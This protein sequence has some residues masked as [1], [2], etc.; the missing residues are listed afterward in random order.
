[1]TISLCHCEKQRDEAIQAAISTH[2]AF[3]WIAAAD[4]QPRDDNNKSNYIVIR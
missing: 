4:Q 1:M 3:P 2:P